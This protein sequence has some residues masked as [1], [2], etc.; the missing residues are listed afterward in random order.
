MG[1][2]R[3]GVGLVGRGCLRNMNSVRPAAIQTSWSRVVARTRWPSTQV[4]FCEFKSLIRKLSPSRQIM[5]CRRESVSSWMVTSAVSSRPKA[6][7]CS[8]ITHRCA[9]APF[10]A[11]KHRSAILDSSPPGCRG[12]TTA[13]QPLPMIDRPGRAKVTHALPLIQDVWA[14]FI[15]LEDQLA[16][17]RVGPGEPL[18]GVLVRVVLVKCLVHEAGAGVGL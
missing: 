6:T 2:S 16:E 3:V 11:N 8:P 18:A 12:T 10:S 5:K 9:A 15:A 1:V 7:G 13:Q 4:P 17:D 14:F